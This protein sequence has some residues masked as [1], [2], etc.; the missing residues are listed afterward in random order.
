MRK[1]IS[2]LNVLYGVSSLF[3]LFVIAE[4]FGAWSSGSLALLGDGAAMSVDV[5]TYFANIYSERKKQESQVLSNSTRRFL[6]I[7]IP[8]FSISCLI[9]VTIYLALD[10]FKIVFMDVD[11]NDFKE[12]V[13]VSYLYGFAIANLLVDIASSALFY[14]RGYG[15]LL[16]E[17]HAHYNCYDSYQ[18]VPTNDIELAEKAD[19]FSLSLSYSH[20]HAHGHGHSHVHNNPYDGSM[21]DAPTFSHDHSHQNITFLSPDSSH[22][23]STSSTSPFY[24][25]DHT[26]SH[27]HQILQSS[28]A[29]TPCAS[30][31][32]SSRST[33]F[34]PNPNN[35][36]S[37]YTSTLEAVH[38]TITRKLNLNM[39][40]ALTHVGGD[41][42]RSISVLIAAII[43]SISSSPY[44]TSTRC[45]A[46]AAIIVT[47]LVFFTS[48]P[49]LISIFSFA[50][51]DFILDDFNVN[52][53]RNNVVIVGDHLLK[54]F[55][56]GSGQCTSSGEP[57]CGSS[58][59]LTASPIDYSHNHD[60]SHVSSTCSGSGGCSST[61]NI[62]GGC[63]SSNSESSSSGCCSNNNKSNCC[64]NSN[65]SGCCSSS[66]LIGKEVS[67]NNYGSV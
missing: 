34:S 47:I 41:T 7:Y 25:L 26:H 45:D 18:N 37:T 28:P 64:S 62:K 3:A 63:C 24:S 53:E 30:C 40:S 31:P 12:D 58:A 61:N 33:C 19:S 36:P 9:F 42:L 23:D 65:K 32:N 27:D 4:I 1:H 20:D 39:L 5:F 56:C 38:C 49:L 51:R 15:G 13:P 48:F 59:P 29:S 35:N 46:W 67:S 43:A 60:H 22:L 50:Y 21:L 66:P 52:N 55:C 57:C 14:W 2:N 6:M 10:A 54:S 16:S 44:L 17:S 11:E 8:L